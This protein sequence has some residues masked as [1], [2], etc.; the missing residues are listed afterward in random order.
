MTTVA[1]STMRVSDEEVTFIRMLKSHG[2]EVNL[3][4]DG[5][6]AHGNASDDEEIAIL[7]G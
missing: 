2:F 5:P 1:V 4:G 6:F 3:I 7:H